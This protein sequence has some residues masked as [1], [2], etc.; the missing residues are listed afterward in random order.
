MFYAL[1]M[2]DPISPYAILGLA[3]SISGAISTG[4]ILVERLIGSKLFSAFLLATPVFLQSQFK[5]DP[6]IA[7]FKL[8]SSRSLYD[9]WDVGFIYLFILLLVLI[10]MGGI[11][12]FLVLN[13][14]GVYNIGIPWLIIWFVVLCSSHMWSAVNQHY[15]E[16]KARH[17]RAATERV[18]RYMMEDPI[19]TIKRWFFY[20]FKNWITAPFTTLYLLLIVIIF[21]LLHWP[22]WLLKGVGILKMDLNDA[23]SRKYYYTGYTVIFLVS[24]LLLMFFFN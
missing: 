10:M 6:A 3:L 20:F 16:I 4:Y 17:K 22:A 11:W 21:V 23:N 18:K 2:F 7:W 24:G 8:R 1:P 9:C 5:D 15:I 13:I 19:N 14:L 12:V